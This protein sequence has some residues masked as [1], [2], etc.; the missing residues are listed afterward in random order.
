ME[1]KEEIVSS[2]SKERK[3]AEWMNNKMMGVGEVDDGGDRKDGGGEPR[4]FYFKI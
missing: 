4:F 2:N 3:M 1:E